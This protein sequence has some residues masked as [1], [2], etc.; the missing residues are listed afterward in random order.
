VIVSADENFG[1]QNGTLKVCKTGADQRIARILSV[2][3]ELAIRKRTSAALHI[4]EK[5][6]CAMRRAFGEGL[7]SAGALGAL[8]L[9]LILIDERVREQMWL[10][11]ARP[12]SGAQLTQAGANVRDLGG[13]ILEALRDQSIE[14]APLLIFGLVGIVLLMLMLRT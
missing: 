3:T 10:R 6:E 5:G 8:L 1:V 12:P 2:G 9:T 11:L 14:H 13:V 4:P 7:M